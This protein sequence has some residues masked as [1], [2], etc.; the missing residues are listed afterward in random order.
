MILP[1]S[2]PDFLMPR[3]KSLS[4]AAAQRSETPAPSTAQRILDAAET[5]F[6]RQGY[7][8]A[9]IRDITQAAGVPLSLARYY[10]GSK[11]ELFMQVLGRRAEETC[12]QLDSSLANAIR[13][14]TTER[15]LEA[16]VDAMISVPVSRLAGGDLGWR[17]YLQLLSQLNQLND[18]TELLQPFRTRYTGT[19]ARYR[20]ALRDAL[21]DASEAVIDWALHFLQILAGHAI[22]DL[23]VTRWVGGADADPIDWLELRRQLVA[24]VVGGMG[25]QLMLELPRGKPAAPRRRSIGIRQPQ[26]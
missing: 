8:A 25:A 13:A 11:D 22:L 14:S 10:Y 12:T 24:H 20:S 2:E 18:R 7:Y 26:P 19:I 15:R 5:I 21:P 3:P 6:A 9:T 16:V 17:H 1:S 4:S 23:A